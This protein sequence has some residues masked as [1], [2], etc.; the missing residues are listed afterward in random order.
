MTYSWNRNRSVDAQLFGDTVEAV[1]ERNNGVCPPSALVDEARPDE[2]PLHPMFEWDDW[3]AA[4]AFR[5][6]QA[7]H[8]IRELRIVTDTDGGTE[9]V[10][11]FV[12]VIRVSGDRLHEG[13]R[14]TSLIVECADEY[15]QVMDE[16]LSGLRAWE[17]RY[18]HL[19]EL[20]QVFDV[21]RQVV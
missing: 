17:R 11:A 7:R 10:Q 18:R 3:V 13:Y 5:R 2:S 4:E 6:D 12:H 15:R 21:I 8:H 9:H 19:S 14:L 16:A 1:S 20:G